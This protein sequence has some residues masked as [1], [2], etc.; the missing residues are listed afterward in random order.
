M[1]EVV[2]QRILQR[3]V[4][5]RREVARPHHRREDDPGHD[6]ERQDPDDPGMQHRQDQAP[7][8]P[9]RRDAQQ[10]GDRTP[11]SAMSG[12]A[13]SVSRTCWTMWTENSVV[14]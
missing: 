13:T 12:A 5:Q 11:T 4:E 8:G 1:L 10:Q 2:D 9:R 14:S 7:P 6:R 3:R